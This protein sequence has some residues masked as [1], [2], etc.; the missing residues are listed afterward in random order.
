[1]R[2]CAFG[3]VAAHVTP[4]TAFPAEFKYRTKADE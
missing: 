3:V 1:M 4:V 2:L